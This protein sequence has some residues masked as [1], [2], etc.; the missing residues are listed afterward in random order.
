MFATAVVAFVVG[1]GVE[2]EPRRARFVRQATD[3]LRRENLAR[4]LASDLRRSGNPS[5][6]RAARRAEFYGRL[7]EKYERAAEHPW[8]PVWPDPP[9]PE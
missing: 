2:C 6:L 3:Y 4:S 9:E 1:V 7:R 5:Y 8:L